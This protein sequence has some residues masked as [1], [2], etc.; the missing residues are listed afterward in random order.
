MRRLWGLLWA[1]LAG[2]LVFWGPWLYLFATTEVE[3]FS[4]VQAADTAIV[5]GALVRNG[6]ISPLHEERL[7]SAKRLVDEGAVDRVV[8]SNSARAA[9]FMVDYMKSVGVEEGIIDIDGTAI[10]TSDTCDRESDVGE[11]RSVVLI[12]QSF[13]LPRLVFQCGRVGVVGQNLAA[14]KVYGQPR[15]GVPLS[16]KLRVRGQRYFREAALT[17]TVIFGVYDRA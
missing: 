12:S 9:S 13:H 11:G 17:W 16:T 14:E 15:V 2:L 6:A 4:T 7:L 10:K 3:D 1:C 8:V 5:F